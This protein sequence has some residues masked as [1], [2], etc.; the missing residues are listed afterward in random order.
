MFVAPKRIPNLVEG[1]DFLLECLVTDP[2][3][4]QLALR[5]AEEP[6]G[7]PPGM[8]V[9]F[10]PRRGA[11]IRNVSLAFRG[12]YVC[13]AQREGREFTSAPFLLLV[14]A[15]KQSSLLIPTSTST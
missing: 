13:S 5:R 14:D 9:T 2:S 10:D 7:L 4:G 8:A 15:S 1:R 12:H 11:L 6:V 3:V